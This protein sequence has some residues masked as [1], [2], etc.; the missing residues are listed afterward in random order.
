VSDGDK[1]GSDRG[2]AGIEETALADGLDTVK[3]DRHRQIGT[4]E[5]ALAPDAATRRD[6]PRAG[7]TSE[8]PALTAGDKL[9]RY[10][11]LELLGSGGMGEV[12]TAYDPELDRRIALKVIRPSAGG[13]GDQT[14][15]R[16]RL[17]R[18]AQAMA[19]LSHPNVIPVFDVGT[20]GEDVY[21][22]MEFVDG[23]DLR[24][25]LDEE[26]RS[27][28]EILDVFL[29]AGAGLAAAH[30]AGLVHRDFKPDNVLI[31]K[32]GRVRV[33]DFGLARQA[34]AAPSRDRVASLGMRPAME[35]LANARHTP[36]TT[37]TGAVMGTPAYM[38][39]EQFE[40]KA[41]DPRTD[42]FNFAVSLYEA[43]FGERPYEGE[44][45]ASLAF[46]VTEGNLRELP[47]DAEIPDW[48]TQAVLV[49]LARDPNDRYA[50]MA[51]MIEALTPQ[52][53]A[54][55]HWPWIAGGGLLLVAATV[56][57]VRFAAGP[58]GPPPCQGLEEP[59]VGVWDASRKAE[60]SAAF[61]ATGL[62]YAEDVWKRV[63]ASLDD[64]ASRWVEARVDA[65]EATA[66]RKEQS[67]EVRG[68]RMA[69][70]DRRLSELDEVVTVMATADVDV[71]DN[72]AQAASSLSSISACANRTL[73]MSG[74]VLADEGI[75]RR[76]ARV[77]A[78]DAAGKYRESL[79]LALQTL[80]L[81]RAT[82]GRP[83]EAPALVWV[84]RLQAAVGDAGEALERLFEAVRIADARGDAASEAEAWVAIVNV[85]TSGLGRPAEGARWA[86]HARL[87]IE[88]AGNDLELQAKLHHAI[89][90]TYFNQ[91][92]YEKALP[93][94]RNAA[95]LYRRIF[96][97]DD[98]RVARSRGMVAST[99]RRMTRFEEAATEHL[100]ALD[101]ME[102]ALGSGHPRV[103]ALLNNAAITLTKLRRFDEAKALYER[104][105]ASRVETFGPDHR[106]VAK[107][108]INLANLEERLG[109]YEAAEQGYQR[110]VAIL[111]STM[112]ADH[113]AIPRAQNQLA[114][115]WR[116]EGRLEEA[117]KMQREVLVR[118]EAIHG[119]DH[120][121]TGNIRAAMCDVLTRQ[122]RY[123]EATTECNHAVQSLL[124]A[125]D[126]RNLAWALT[127]SGKLDVLRGRADAAVPKL[128]KALAIRDRLPGDD[129]YL[130]ETQA[131]LAFALDAAGADRA[132]AVDL[133]TKARQTL[134]DLPLGDREWLPEI[135]AWLKA[136]GQ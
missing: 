20:L 5:T 72:A 131:A 34:G 49:G 57:A 39:P 88:Q 84:G 73:L 62:A 28:R 130:A 43:L 27:W 106:Q 2:I 135:E 13:S 48:L 108:L 133:A 55:L 124:D 3:E 96:G 51:E 54:R 24:A 122:G 12:Y 4:E 85:T 11:V 97:E 102:H 41:T 18:E 45:Y 129:I 100:A 80:E 101:A 112:G 58:G 22:A 128:E 81:A 63:E 104:A 87:A 19:Q 120:E 9:G 117:A 64:Y 125:P 56:L 31:G 103:A 78:L 32:D 68:R 15:T 71:I 127:Y 107:P 26:A 14:E 29:A 30:A 132:R 75:D 123:R 52:E 66:V 10:V 118:Y 116:R 17:A 33:I 46:N 90:S 61:R 36:V 7:A 136:R 40:G 134:L 91:K 76:L 38:A 23:R 89:G 113:P 53:R 59:L 1:S 70:L 6:E 16:G 83:G 44:T 121:L 60:V 8:R 93:E 25:W 50:S 94:Y 119:A 35:S 126:Q 99:L 21:V 69:C 82:P 92:E 111:E 115:L 74:A 95:A 67:D 42:Q 77:K 79:V 110:A 65:C 47:A 114:R 105:I 109:N 86:E 37:E 98:W